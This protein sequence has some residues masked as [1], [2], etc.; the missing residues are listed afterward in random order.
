LIE[1]NDIRQLQAKARKSKVFGQ[2]RPIG[3]SCRL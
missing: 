1:L 2:L 3:R